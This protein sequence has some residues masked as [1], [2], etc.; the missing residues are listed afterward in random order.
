MPNTEKQI[1]KHPPIPG[2]RYSDTNRRYFAKIFGGR[3][4]VPDTKK[5][6]VN[7]VPMPGTDTTGTSLV[8]FSLKMS[9]NKEI[10]KEH[11]Y[12]W[13]KKEIIPILKLVLEEHS[14]EMSTSEVFFKFFSTF[15]YS[16][17]KHSLDHKF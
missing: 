3:Y 16:T 15:K 6:P 5:M 9:L 13:R 4:R 10:L 8:I 14:R 11:L 2:N 7:R 1:P 12:Q 17:L